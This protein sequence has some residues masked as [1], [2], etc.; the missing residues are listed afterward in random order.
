M[1]QYGGQEQ[2]ICQMHFIFITLNRI[3]TH[4]IQKNTGSHKRSR[5][6]CSFDFKINLGLFTINSFSQ[7]HFAGMFFNSKYS[8]PTHIL[9]ICFSLA[10]IL[11][12]FVIF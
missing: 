11:I 4:L 6:L 1:I 2:K 5:H 9:A 3:L 8:A 12:Y 7:N 10:F